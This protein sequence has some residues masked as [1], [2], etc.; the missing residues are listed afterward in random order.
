M[1]ILIT[2]PGRCID[3]WELYQDLKRYRVNVMDLGTVVYVYKNGITA[4]QIANVLAICDKYGAYSVSE[5]QR[6]KT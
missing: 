2:F 3:S 4:T 5:L 6:N 1:W